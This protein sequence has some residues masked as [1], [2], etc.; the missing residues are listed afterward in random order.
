MAKRNTRQRIIET[1]LRL[2]NERHFGNVTTAA[3]AAELGMTEGNLWYHFKSKRDLLDAIAERYVAFARERLAIVPGED[4][5][6]E[7]YARLLAALSDEVRSFRCIFRDRP[8]YG[9]FPASLHDA[10]GAIYEASWAQMGRFFA[11]LKTAGHL[12]IPD[13][14]IGPLVT[15]SIV[16]IRFAPELF[17]EMNMSDEDMTRMADWGIV[18]HLDCFGDWLKPEARRRLVARLNLDEAIA[19]ASSFPGAFSRRP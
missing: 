9:E 17:R 3:L 1:A 13:A 19:T 2:F 18:H 10:A 8:D 7:D 11:A 14:W 12:D 15:N 4:D 5:V 16:V 6:L